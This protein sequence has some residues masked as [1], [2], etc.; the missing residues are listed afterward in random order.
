MVRIT[1]ACILAV[2]LVCLLTATAPAQITTPLPDVFFVNYFAN[3]HNGGADGTVRIMNPGLYTTPNTAGV[4]VSRDLCALIY[5]WDQDQE[6][7]E[8]CGCKITPNGVRQLSVNNDLTDNA[9]TGGT[10][11]DGGIKIVSHPATAAGS[12]QRSSG[13]AI[14]ITNP[15]ATLRAWIT[16]PQDTRVEALTEE[17]FLDVNLSEGERRLLNNRCTGIHNLGSSRGICTCGNGG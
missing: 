6:L 1:T 11:S 10:V 16:H 17:E 2:G 5:V 7:K 4:P 3:A 8:C 9:L 15:Q 14:L 12:W 13:A